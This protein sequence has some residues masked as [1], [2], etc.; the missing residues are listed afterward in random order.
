MDFSKFKTSDWLKIGGAAGFFI[1][2]FFGW[3]KFSFAGFSGGS[4]NAFDFFWTGTLPWLLIVASGVISFLVAGG[5][6]KAKIP[7]LPMIVLVATALG[8]LLVLIRLIF[9]P[10]GGPSF[11][12]SRGFGLFVASIAA[13]VATVGAFLSFTE[14]GGNLKDLTN[15]DKLKG[16]FGSGGSDGNT[17]PPPPPPSI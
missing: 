12:I 4:A 8:T 3:V 9:N 1:F 7:S 16:Q 6:I 13:V 11:G 5:I 10:L 17:P 2:A 14:S 15:V